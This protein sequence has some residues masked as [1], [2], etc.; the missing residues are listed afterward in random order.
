MIYLQFQPLLLC[1]KILVKYQDLQFFIKDLFCNLYETL[2]FNWES[3]YFSEIV[4]FFSHKNLK[5]A[6]ANPDFNV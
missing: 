2:L 4:L 3:V 6:L 5:I 1:M